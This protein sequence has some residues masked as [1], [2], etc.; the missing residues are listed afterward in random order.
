MAQTEVKNN[1]SV[2]KGFKSWLQIFSQMIQDMKKMV[3][4]LNTDEVPD[5]DALKNTMDL[6]FYVIPYSLSKAQAPLG[7]CD[8]LV[9]VL[10]KNMLADIRKRVLKILYTLNDPSTCDR[11]QFSELKMIYDKFYKWCVDFGAITYKDSINET[12]YIARLI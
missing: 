9:P 10:I 3:A 4:F 1:E 2:N 7:D 8:W 11:K 5:N 6:F 12:R